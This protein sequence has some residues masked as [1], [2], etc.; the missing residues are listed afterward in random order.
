MFDYDIYAVCGDGC[1]MEGVGS[2]A[3]SLAG[4]LGLDNLCWVYDN[5]HITIEGSTRL[6][7]TEDVAARFMGYGWNVLRV[8]DANDLDLIGHALG[9]FRATKGRPTLVILDSHIGYGS[10]H[11]QDTAAAHGEP[12]GEEEVR[13]TKRAYGWP[14]DAKFLVP[15]GVREHFAAGIGAR[16]AEARRKWTDLFAGYRAKYP[17]LAA[18]VDQMQ[19]RELPAGWDRNLPVFPADPKG[20]A[21]RDA[22]GPG[23]ERPRAE[24]ALVARRLGGPRAVEQDHAQVRGRGRRAGRHARRQ[25]PALRHPRARDGRDRERDVALEAAARSARRSSS[26]ATTRGRRSGSRR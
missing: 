17:E 14:E 13:L 11:R 20:I 1:L 7:F 3:A 4:H 19:K 10:P 23:A 16:G 24:R 5:N 26:S 2:E 25:E 21:G 18:E 22:S 9:V 6:A 8:G 15:D 12:L